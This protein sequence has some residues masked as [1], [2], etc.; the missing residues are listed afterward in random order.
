MQPWRENK[1]EW[2]KAV[3]R[4]YPDFSKR[5]CALRELF[6]ETNIL[7]S[8]RNDIG[9]DICSLQNYIHKYKND[10]V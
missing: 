3:G 8:R 6:E 7:L 9:A 2:F 1:A 4:G 10:F 5:V